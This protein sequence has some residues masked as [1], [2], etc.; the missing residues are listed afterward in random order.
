MGV[1]EEE[2]SE[3]PKKWNVAYEQRLKISNNFK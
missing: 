2:G 1:G 3:S